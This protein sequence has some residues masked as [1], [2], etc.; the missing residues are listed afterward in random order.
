LQLIGKL[1]YSTP[2]THFG[3]R[4]YG[5]LKYYIYFYYYDGVLMMHL[6]YCSPCSCIGPKPI[7]ERVQQPVTLRAGVRHCAGTQVSHIYTYYFI[8]CRYILIYWLWFN[9]RV[10]TLFLYHYRT[11]IQRRYYIRFE[12]WSESRKNNIRWAC[13]AKDAEVFRLERI[14]SYRVHQRR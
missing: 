6:S 4:I 7:Q 9:T 13:E 1:F 11:H 14:T 10:C 5:L 3:C 2:K 8:Q 12:G